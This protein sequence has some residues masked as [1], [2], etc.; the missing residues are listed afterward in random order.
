M[1]VAIFAGNVRSLQSGCT[2][3]VNVEGPYGTFSGTNPIAIGNTVFFQD[4]LSR[5]NAVSKKPVL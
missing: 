5:L 1:D 4:M 2:I 3:P